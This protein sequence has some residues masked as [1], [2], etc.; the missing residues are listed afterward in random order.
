MGDGD[1]GVASPTEEAGPEEPPQ[2][3][4]EPLVDEKQIGDPSASYFSLEISPDMRFLLWQEVIG[5]SAGPVWIAGIDPLTA[6]LVPQDGRGFRIDGVSGSAAPQWGR[7]AKGL[8]LVTFSTTGKVLIVRP[9]SATEATTEEVDVPLDPSRAYPYA[10]RISSRNGALVAY[11]K[12]DT[13]RRKQIYWLD[14]AASPV[15]ETA[16]TSGPVNLFE[17]RPSFIVTVYRW[18][19]ESTR[20]FWGATTPAGSPSAK[21]QIL[22]VDLSAPSAAPKF[23]TNDDSNHVDDF[24]TPLGGEALLV[25]GVDNLAKG[26]VYKPSADG[27]FKKEVDIVPKSGFPKAKFAASF[28]AFTADSRRLA[29]F[30]VLDDGDKPGSFPAE[31]WLADLRAGQTGIISGSKRLNRLDPE[32]FLGTKEVFILHYARDPDAPGSGYKIYRLRTGIPR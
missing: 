16:L 29:S 30:I 25:G 15:V 12:D 13:Q 20:L 26:A 21:L 19:D 28:E 32:F 27:T 7:D 17:G 14:T 4:F 18:L 8:S 22:S 9:S 31:V 1:A 24:P 10:T 5:G 6:E 2:Q 3:A 23:V 11:L